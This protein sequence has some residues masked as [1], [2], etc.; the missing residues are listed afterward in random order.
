M[1]VF[2]INLQSRG[3]PT[4]KRLAPDTCSPAEPLMGALNSNV[5]NEALP[6]AV[7]S[8][9]PT[10]E[11]TLTLTLPATINV[12]LSPV[13]PHTSKHNVNNRT[14]DHGKQ[15]RKQLE[16][17]CESAMDWAWWCELF[18]C[19]LRWLLNPSRSAVVPLRRGWPPAACLWTALGFSLQCVIS[20]QNR[21]G[22]AIHVSSA[23]W[24]IG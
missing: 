5:S 21:K 2:R 18:S 13:T 20:T 17:G 3:D 6:L 14:P 9:A 23:S 22:N 4:G 11:A 7:A 24:T 1:R 15:E 10:I 12:A 19:C 16:F 8:S